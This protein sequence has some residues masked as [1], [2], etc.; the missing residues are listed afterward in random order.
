MIRGRIIS[1]SLPD[2]KDDLWQ[3]P[4]SQTSLS[5][6]VGA[7]PSKVAD[8]LGSLSATR[9]RG[10]GS[11]GCA[12]A[13]HAGQFGPGA[14]PSRSQSR[15]GS[16]GTAAMPAHKGALRGP[17]HKRPFQGDAAA[18]PPL[19]VKYKEPGCVNSTYLPQVKEQ[20]TPWVDRNR[21]VET[22]P[23]EGKTDPR[24]RLG[25][26]HDFT[27]LPIRQKHL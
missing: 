14:G 8:K 18:N 13:A 26:R 4:L 22:A 17:R 2:N 10:K 11:A 6:T 16:S 9:P 19:S 12:W 5:C 7:V 3:M 21:A 27:C 24:P 15:P 25:F 20:N 23:N 1:S